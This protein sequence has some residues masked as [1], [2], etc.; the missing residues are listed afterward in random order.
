[1]L[2]IDDGFEDGTADVA[3]ACGADHMVRFRSHTGLAAAIIVDIDAS[4]K[5]DADFIVNTDSDNQR[6]IFGTSGPS[7]AY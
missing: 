4:L 3:R 7:F 5:L 2:V 6:D 1:M